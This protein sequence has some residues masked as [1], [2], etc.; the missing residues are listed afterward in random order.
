MTQTAPTAPAL[1]AFEKVE[2]TFTVL[3]TTGEH[4]TVRIRTQAPDARFAPGAKVVGVLTGPDN[5]RSYTGVGFLAPEG[6]RPWR[7][8]EGTMQAR[9]AGFVCRILLGTQALPEGYSLE[10]SRAC[11]ACGRRLTT[12]ES[13]ALGIG[14]ECRKRF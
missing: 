14:P 3:S 11:V 5:E 12:P 7:R 6:F 4:R 2:G 13:L 10:E 9:V 1:T 8:A